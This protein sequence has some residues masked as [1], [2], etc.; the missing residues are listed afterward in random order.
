MGIQGSGK[1]ELGKSFTKNFKFPFYCVVNLDDIDDV[2]KNCYKIIMKKRN[3]LELE[4][5]CKELIELSK[6]GKCDAVFIDEADMLIPKIIEGLQKFPAMYDLFVNHRH[7]GVAV[8]FMTRRPQD[9]NP[10]VVE[11]CE[12]KFVFALETSDNITRKM[13]AIDSRLPEMMQSV[14]KKSHNF[15]H[16]QLGET[17]VLMKAIKLEAKK[18][19]GKTRSKKVPSDDED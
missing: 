18:K 7:Y 11:S 2:D 1:S 17:P 5:I 12:H 15:I 3:A 4:G 14:T 19:N 16:K 9:L 10:L 8:F 6:R 13:K